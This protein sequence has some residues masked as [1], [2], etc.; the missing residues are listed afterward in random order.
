MAA[1]TTGVFREI[2]REKRLATLA[3]PGRISE[4]CGIRRTSSNVSP[5]RG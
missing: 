1:L 2:L 3:S 5:G 4:Y